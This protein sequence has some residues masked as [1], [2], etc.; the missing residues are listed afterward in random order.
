MTWYT[1]STLKVHT[2]CF[3]IYKQYNIIQIIAVIN[4]AIS[5]RENSFR[6][7]TECTKLKY[8]HFSSRWA[9]P[10]CSYS[11]QNLL[12]VGLGSLYAAD[13]ASA[14]GASFLVSPLICIVDR[15]IMQN[16]SG[17]MKMGDSVRWAP[18]VPCHTESHDSIVCFRPI[19]CTSIILWV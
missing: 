17:A 1:S 6:I 11:F 16:A 4:C 18:F 10:S 12:Q 7:V 5:Y 14:V 2:L 9:A 8:F 13:L 19:Y 3:F 15:S